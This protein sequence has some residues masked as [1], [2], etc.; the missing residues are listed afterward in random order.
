MGAAVEPEA[1]AMTD[2]LAAILDRDPT[3]WSETDLAAVMRSP[4]YRTPGAP[5]RA[6][7]VGKATAWF[8]QRYGGGPVHVRAYTRD[9]G[10]V[11][12]R[13]YD[14]SGP[15]SSGDGSTE[16]AEAAQTSEGGAAAT[17]AP[18]AND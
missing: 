18:A 2:S 11:Q 4:T 14:R 8:Q 3:S 10:T 5:R 16:T 6:E 12:V 13:A 7:A 15:P 9:G 17:S 1:A